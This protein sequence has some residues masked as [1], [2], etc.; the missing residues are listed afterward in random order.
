MSQPGRELLCKMTEMGFFSADFILGHTLQFIMF[1]IIIIPYVDRVHSM[2]L[3][4]LRPSR[5]IRPPIY[6]AKQS[7]LRRKRVIRFSVLYFFMLVIF[8]ALFIGPAVA[9]KS[10]AYTIDFRQLTQY[11]ERNSRDIS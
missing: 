5:Q 3:F 1:P 6:T 9:S 10:P 11:R 4:W 2:M 8:L 7:K